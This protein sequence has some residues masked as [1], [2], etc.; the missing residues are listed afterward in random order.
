MRR[1]VTEASIAPGTWA[2]SVV[3]ITLWP[4]AAQLA[5]KQLAALAV[6]LAHDV[7]EQ[8][9]RRAAA[10]A[11][12]HRALGQQQRQQR[13]ALLALGAV[14]AQLAPVAQDRELVAVGPVAGEATLEVAGQPLAQLGQEL[15]LAGGARARPVLEP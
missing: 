1:R 14:D 10:F 13:Q 8:H 2:R 7:V 3:A 15:L 6:E 9:Q 5:G 12:Q 11:G 4:P